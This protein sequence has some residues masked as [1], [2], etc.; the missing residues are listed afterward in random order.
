MNINQEITIEKSVLDFE[1]MV[2][3]AIGHNFE[4][5]ETCAENKYSNDH[6]V[7]LYFIFHLYA[8][9]VLKLIKLTFSICT[10]I[11]YS[12][13]QDSNSCFSRKYMSSSVLFQ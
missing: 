4:G 10:H 6:F 13:K 2:V 5:F 8:D 1:I 12:G 9:S 7:S 11:Y 3:N